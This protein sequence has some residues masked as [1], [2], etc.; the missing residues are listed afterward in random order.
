MLKKLRV[1]M[2]DDIEEELVR[3]KEFSKVIKKKC[4]PQTGGGAAA[5]MPTEKKMKLSEL[6]TMQEESLEYCIVT[7]EMQMLG[8]YLKKAN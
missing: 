3:A 4:G 5:Q 2:P 8:E 1:E 7:S 6:L